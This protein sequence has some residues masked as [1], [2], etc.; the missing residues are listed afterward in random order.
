MTTSTAAASTSWKLLAERA[1]AESDPRRR[2]LLQTVLRHLESEVAGDLDTTMATL[3]DDPDYRVWGATD[4]TGPRGRE[5]IR[6][7]YE[8]QQAIGKNLLEYHV[9]RV[10]VDADV[11]TEGVFRH[12]YQ[13]A[14]LVADGVADAADVIPDQRY[15]IEYR[16]LV[17]W[18]MSPDGLIEGEDTYKAEPARVVRRLE[19]DELPHLGLP[20][21][22]RVS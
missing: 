20:P 3:T 1:D 12:A 17:V 8:G 7:M 22:T 9:D 4:H 15:L 19:A 10:L 11:V 21:R 14:Q 6:R 5:A 16:A 13:G 2:A 18:V